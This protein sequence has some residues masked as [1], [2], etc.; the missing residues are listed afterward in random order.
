MSEVEAAFLQLVRP[1]W[2]RLHLVA[3]NYA[4][5]SEGARDLVQETLLRAWAAY[6]PGEGQSYREGWLFVIQ[7]RIAAEWARQSHRRIRLKLVENE[8]LTDLVGAELSEPFESLPPTT[9]AQ[10]REFLDQYAVV[11][12]DSLEP[13]F[14]EV[15]LLSVAAELSYR[16]IAD[17]LGFPLGT[18]MSRM[19]RARRDLREKLADAAKAAGWKIKKSHEPQAGETK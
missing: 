15:L 14:R 6:R 10:F 2:R 19:A 7:R 13:S 5:T 4:A 1:C 11:A 16:E 8:E 17:V 3:R 9:E 12:L 18:V